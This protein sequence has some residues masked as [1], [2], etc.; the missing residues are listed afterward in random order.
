MAKK[1][2]KTAKKYEMKRDDIR[3]ALEELYSRLSEIDTVNE[4]PQA[5]AETLG[6]LMSDVGDLQS[7][8]FDEL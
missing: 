5:V 1:A 3:A 2:V 8:I 7:Q 6:D 4:S